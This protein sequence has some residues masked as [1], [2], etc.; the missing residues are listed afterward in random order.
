MRSHPPSSPLFTLSSFI[1]LWA[2]IFGAAVRLAAPALAGFPL[3]DGGLFY[4]MAQDI[5][6]ND[7]TLPLYT[8]Y[9]AAHIPL[10]YPPL[11][12]YI[13]AFLVRAF[14]FELI[15]VLRWLPPLVSVL[16][17]PA[18]NLLSRAVLKDRLQAALATAAFAMLPAA[19]DLNFLGGGL[20]RSFG[21]LFCLLTLY[22]AY[23]LYTRRQVRFIL[24]TALFASGMILAHPESSFHTLFLVC[25][26]WFFFGRDRQSL[27]QSLLVA[28]VI[29]IATSPWWLAI[30]LRHGITPFVSILQSGWHQPLFWLPLL[31]FEFPGERFL[32]VVA[33]LGVLGL[34]FCLARKAYFLP[35]WLIVPFVAEPRNP[36]FFAIISL[37]MLAAMG[38]EQVVL[39]GPGSFTIPKEAD[40]DEAKEMAWFATPGGR[41]LLAFF[42]IYPLINAF[43]T[44]LQFSRYVLSKEERAALQWVAENTPPEARFLVLAFGGTFS[45]PIQEWFPA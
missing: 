3:M 2:L 36:G 22:G 38:F 14:G 29:F 23:E 8:S 41:L 16:T 11:T 26:L 10:A 17:I 21:A 1:V 43:Y 9:N 33:V 44:S 24:L 35:A 12:F 7:F 15:Q 18:F 30:V 28:V 31:T 37:A 25:L 20:T 32:D 42:L 5:L 4:T 39:R 13:A 45:S 34:I 6:R 40:R 27:L 19:F